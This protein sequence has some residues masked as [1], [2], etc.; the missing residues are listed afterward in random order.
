[1]FYAVNVCLDLPKYS[2]CTLLMIFSCIFNLPSAIIFLW[3]EY[4]LWDRFYWQSIS[5]KH[6]HFYL[7]KNKLIN[8]FFHGLYFLC[9]FKMALP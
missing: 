7:S 8:L 4:V 1:M 9:V 6:L 2:P 5:G 3:L